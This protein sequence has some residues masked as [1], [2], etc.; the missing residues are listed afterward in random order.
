MG[1]RFAECFALADEREDRVVVGQQLEEVERR[2]E[3]EQPGGGKKAFQDF[4]FFL[5]LTQKTAFIVKV[6]TW[7]GY[8]EKKNS[9]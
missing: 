5:P 9:D 7:S 4:V 6:N 8:D 1:G 2:R 3:E